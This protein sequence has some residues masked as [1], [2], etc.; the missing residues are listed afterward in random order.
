MPVHGFIISLD[1]LSESGQMTFALLHP[2]LVTFLEYGG[3][4]H[5]PSTAL[6]SIRKASLYI[7]HFQVKE[8]I[9]S[10]LP[11]KLPVTVFDL[12]QAELPRTELYVSPW[13]CSYLFPWLFMAAAAEPTILVSGPKMGLCKDLKRSCMGS[14]G[15]ESQEDMF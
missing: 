3:S 4:T 5:S 9:T 8:K 7:F 1:C 11:F 14:E 2:L 6:R 15:M 12:I 10:K 13:P